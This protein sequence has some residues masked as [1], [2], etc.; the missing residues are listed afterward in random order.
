MNQS[1]H[2]TRINRH[3]IRPGDIQQ[4]VFQP[5]GED[6]KVLS[7]PVDETIDIITFCISG[8]E[9]DKLDMFGNPDIN[10]YPAIYDE[11]LFDGRTVQSQDRQDA[12]AKIELKQG[13]SY[14]FIKRGP[15]GRFFDPLGLY[16]RN[17]KTRRLGEDI[18]KYRPVNPTVMKLYLHYLRTKNKANLHAAEREMI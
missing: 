3:R 17:S 11:E 10:G 1:E 15:D 7:E 16:D 8:I 2:N 13:N 5:K 6:G 14:Y 12:C 4:A 18:W 9:D